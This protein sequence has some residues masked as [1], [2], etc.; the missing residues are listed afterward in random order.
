MT[1]R[2]IKYPKE[3]IEKKTSHYGHLA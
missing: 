3:Y 2:H 1:S